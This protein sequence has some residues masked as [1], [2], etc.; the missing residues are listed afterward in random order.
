[1]DQEIER[2][3]EEVKI[4]MK[5]SEWYYGILLK[6]NDY[7]CGN[8]EASY[9]HYGDNPPF[10]CSFDKCPKIDPNDKERDYKR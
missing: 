9:C 5:Y 6:C 8:R 4:R 1:V 7:T 2:Q 3:A 10:W